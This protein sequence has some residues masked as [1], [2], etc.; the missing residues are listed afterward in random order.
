MTKMLV[1]VLPVL[2]SLAQNPAR[3]KDLPDKGSVMAVYFHL[4]A[5]GHNIEFNEKYLRNCLNS[6]TDYYLWSKG[7]LLIL[8]ILTASS[9]FLN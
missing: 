2:L 6:H 9:A 1:A 5:I 7:G 3:I 4:A 8:Y